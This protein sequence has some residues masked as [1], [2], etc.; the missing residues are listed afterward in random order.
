MRNLGSKN[1]SENISFKFIVPIIYVRFH[2]YLYGLMK[3]IA[4]HIALQKQKTK[5]NKNIFE[6]EL[7]FKFEVVEAVFHTIYSDDRM[8]LQRSLFGQ[9]LAASLSSSKKQLTN[10]TFKVSV[11]RTLVGTSKLILHK[12]YFQTFLCNA[13]HRA[14][15]VNSEN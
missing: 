4:L 6:E 3:N 11:Y 1:K 7:N 8:L 9:A 5:Q 2:S 15:Q 14:A 12:F 13:L 10:I